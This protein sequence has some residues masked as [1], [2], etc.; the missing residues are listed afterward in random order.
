MPLLV[1]C[2]IVT[3]YCDT[4][5]LCLDNSDHNHGPTGGGSG[6]GSNDREDDDADVSGGGA[7]NGSDRPFALT[8]AGVDDSDRPRV[9]DSNGSSKEE[10]SE[11]ANGDVSKSSNSQRSLIV[12][13]SSLTT[14]PVDGRPDVIIGGHG[15]ILGSSSAGVIA[16]VISRNV[17][18]DIGGVTGVASRG[19]CNVGGMLGLGLGCG[20]RC[21]D[22]D[23][24]NDNNLNSMSAHFTMEFDCDSDSIS[25][26]PTETADSVSNI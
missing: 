12:S 19:G 10:S 1:F 14:D 5:Q 20:D 25:S 24:N 23:N 2:Y 16:S 3:L 21:V 15:A 17:I 6:T 13:K 22:G 4:Y 11:L 8:R 26:N 18:A 7:G 9:A